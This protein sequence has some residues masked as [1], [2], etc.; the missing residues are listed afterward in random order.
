MMAAVPGGPRKRFRA[1]AGLE[2]RSKTGRQAAERVDWF[3]ARAA[4]ANF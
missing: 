3:F 2:L 4:Q 1:A